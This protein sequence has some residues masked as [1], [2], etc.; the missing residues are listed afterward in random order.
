M[1]QEGASFWI[2]HIAVR[3]RCYEYPNYEERKEREE[4]KSD[5]QADGCLT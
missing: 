4:I 3:L 1:T 2:L 5:S